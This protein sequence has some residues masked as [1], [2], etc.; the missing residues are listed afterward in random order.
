VGVLAAGWWQSARR[1]LPAPGPVDIGFAQAMSR[2]HQQAIAMAQLMLEGSPTPLTTLARQIAATQLVEFGEMQGWLKL[3]QAPV[4][5]LRPSMEWMLQGR[6]APDDA[7]RQYLLDCAQAPTGMAGLA[8]DAEVA[9]L[10]TLS[11]R[12]R[13]AHFLALM[14]AHHEG[15]LPMARFATAEARLPV[16]RRLAAEVVREQSHELMV[17]Q[18]TQ[19]VVAALEAESSG[20]TLAP[21]S[22]VEENKKP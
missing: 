13:D 19:E 2:H 14:R 20:A 10:R 11:G 4:Q 7:L 21:Q 6:R 12:A 5:P 17:I 9:R 18:R 8:T 16:V 3:W 22:A 15:G 1:S